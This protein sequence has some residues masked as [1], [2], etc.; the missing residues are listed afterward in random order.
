MNWTTVSLISLQSFLV[1][2]QLFV[3]EG[4]LFFIEDMKDHAATYS[5]NAGNLQH[6]ILLVSKLL[7][8]QPDPHKIPFFLSSYKAVFGCLYN[9]FLI[10]VTL[11]VTNA[12]CERSFS[13]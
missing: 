1:A 11:L 4:T 6:K 3:L 2:F 9:L 8:K 10:S 7:L 5:L 12:S 13:K